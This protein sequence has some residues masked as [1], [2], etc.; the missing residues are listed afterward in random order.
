MGILDKMVNTVAKKIMIDTA[1]NG[2][3]KTVGAVADY[4]SK[5]ESVDFKT[6]KIPNSSD[7]YLGM[8]YKYALEEL[9]AYGFTN[10]ALLPK[11][12]LIKGWIIKDGAV[13]EVSIN[14]KTEFKGKNKFPNNARVVIAYHT[15]RDSR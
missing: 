9:M 11:K 8:N 10:I 1:V 7:H 15:F 4:N 13:E 5:R 14:G 2:A 12:D 3:V 6:I